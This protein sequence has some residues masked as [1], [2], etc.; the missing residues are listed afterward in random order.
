[1]ARYGVRPAV[2]E[3]LEGTA[4]RGCLLGLLLLQLINGSLYLIVSH[5]LTSDGMVKDVR[6]KPR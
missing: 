6:G 2:P 4:E 1:M 3:A 5:I